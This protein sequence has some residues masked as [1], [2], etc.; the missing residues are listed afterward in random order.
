MHEG[1]IL[2]DMGRLG[3]RKIGADVFV[4]LILYNSKNTFDVIIETVPCGQLS[5]AYPHT[6]RED[7]LASRPAV[8]ARTRQGHSVP[9][10]AEELLRACIVMKKL[11]T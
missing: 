7:A 8:L 2:A 10:T 11:K 6:L 9:L 3:T 5:K 4:A 1:N